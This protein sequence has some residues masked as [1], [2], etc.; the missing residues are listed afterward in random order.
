MSD[1]LSC[2]SGRAPVTTGGEPVAHRLTCAGWVRLRTNDT[3]D[4][5]RTRAR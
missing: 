2:A 3:T 5:D 4:V 1:G